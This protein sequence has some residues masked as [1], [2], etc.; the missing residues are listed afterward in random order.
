MWAFVSMVRRCLPCG[1]CSHCAQCGHCVDGVDNVCIV[2]RLT[3]YTIVR[4]CGHGL[5]F[6]IVSVGFFVL[7]EVLWL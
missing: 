2:N 7:S 6:W 1:P 4:R 5:V 3:V